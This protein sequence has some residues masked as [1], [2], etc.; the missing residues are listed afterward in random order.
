MSKT[1][2]PTPNLDAFI[3]RPQ[4]SFTVVLQDGE[5][6]ACKL[7]DLGQYDVHVQT[8]EGQL[9]IPKHFV[10]Y[11]ILHEEE[12]AEEKKD[13]PPTLILEAIVIPPSF[14]RSKPNPAKVKEKIGYYKKH[15][16]FDKPIKVNK[17]QKGWLLID[18]Y[19]RYIAALEMGLSET[20]VEIE[21]KSS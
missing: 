19:S 17:T 2:G 9:L 7:L 18:G 20:Q 5:K 1:K 8:E 15:G 13:L 21:E 12:I 3:L 4:T 16:K 6:I 10:K 11:Y 14:K